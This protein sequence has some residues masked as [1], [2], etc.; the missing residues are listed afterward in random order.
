MTRSLSSDRTNF[1]KDWAKIELGNDANC[2]LQLALGKV[3]CW[4]S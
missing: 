4:C 3:L 1:A 2:Q